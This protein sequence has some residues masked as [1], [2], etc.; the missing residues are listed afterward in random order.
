MLL[1]FFGWRQVFTSIALFNML[2]SPLNA[3]PWVLNGLM[4]AWVSVKR[5]Q[6]FLSLDNLDL[7]GYYQQL[8]CSDKGESKSIVVYSNLLNMLLSVQILQKKGGGEGEW[9]QGRGSIKSI[10]KMPPWGQSV[11]ILQYYIK[12]LNEYWKSKATFIHIKIEV[13]FMVEFNL[14][15][16]YSQ[17]STWSFII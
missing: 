14:T 1:L 8:D 10:S 11:L 16:F 3:F 6:A 13:T 9:R 5:I 15:D 2:I 17:M 7:T 4:E 12:Q